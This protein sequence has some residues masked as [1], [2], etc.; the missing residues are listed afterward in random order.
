VDPDRGETGQIGAEMLLGRLPLH[1]RS[2]LREEPDRFVAVTVEEESADR[3][4][5][6]LVTWPKRSFEDWWKEVKG[7]LNPQAG[8]PVSYPYVLPAAPS[9]ACVN[10]TWAN[11][12]TAVPYT[13]T[14]NSMIWTGTEAIVWGGVSPV[15]FLNTGHRYSPATDTWTS[16]A[17]DGSTPSPRNAHTAVWTGSEMIVW[18]GFGP[19]STYL[20][21]GGRYNPAT[22]TWAPV[23]TDA[24]SPT[25]RRGHS[26]IWTGTR[27]IIWGGSSPPFFPPTNY[28]TFLN[29]GASYDPGTDAWTATR[30]DATT[31]EVREGHV[32]VW[33]GTEM[34]LW[35]GHREA[36]TT[37]WTF[38]DLS[39]GGRYNPGTD[40]WTAMGGAPPQ[41]R[42]NHTGI[43]TGTEMIV[44][45]GIFRMINGITGQVTNVYLNSGGRYN[46]STNAWTA[47]RLDG[48]TP[49]ARHVH[50]AV[51]TG[52]QMIVWGG[53]Y[54]TSGST[55]YAPLGGRYN[56]ANDTWAGVY[57]PGPQPRSQHGAVWTGSEM[58]VW[59]GTGYGGTKT[60]GGRYNPATDSWIG[61]AVEPDYYGAAVWTGSEMIV[62]GLSSA[63]DPGGTSPAG[64]YSPATD[65]WHTGSVANAPQGRSSSVA[66]WTG[67]EMIVWGGDNLVTGGRYNPT[68][69][70]WTP[71]MVNGST[72]IARQGG[73]PVAVWTGS[74]MMI[75]GGYCTVTGPCAG[76]RYNPLTDSWTAMRADASAPEKRVLHTGIWT[77]SEMI[78]YGGY[79]GYRPS[80]PFVIGDYARYD[81]A[82]DQWTVSAAPDARYQHTAVWTG[83]EM[84]VWGGRVFDGT[85]EVPT[86]TGQRY[87]PA[88]NAFQPSASGSGTPPARNSH[89]A[90]WDGGEM[91]IWG[92]I[93]GDGTFL[94]DGGRYNP[95][96][97][98]WSPTKLDGTTPLPRY[99]HLAVWTGDEMIIWS[100]LA[101][102]Q[103]SV[104]SFNNGGRYCSCAV[105]V[106][107][108]LDL[109]GDG[110]G[111]SSTGQ[112]F[113][114]VPADRVSAGGD[115][116]DNDPGAWSLPGEAR[117]LTL[118]DN[119]TLVW[120]APITPGANS[121]LYDLIRSPT[122]SDFTGSGTCVASNTPSLGASDAIMP[123][124]GSA[125][126]YLVR[127]ENA[128]P[129]GMGPLGNNSQGNPRSALNCP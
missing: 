26:A 15:G 74:E 14:G 114:G 57:S 23:K 68:L 72:P 90:V 117:D 75:W 5:L 28:P 65:T 32:A 27:M 102:F 50:T 71:T 104:V 84:I 18:G 49:A 111:D 31:P 7:S 78:I 73:L 124:P 120:S 76:G 33:T 12:H 51:W 62:W 77:G 121:L 110:T 100:G 109:D 40:T 125:L 126:Y 88:A 38:R 19:G 86:N 97:G 17:V 113:C 82:A 123:P 25:A 91:I 83:T 103:G 43:W 99:S 6:A 16:T 80:A 122:A 92:G 79:D 37:P 98:S 101:V 46:P 44:W 10:D 13:R 47:T 69:D 63:V 107:Y 35:G 129:G 59:G 1:R 20:G 9:Q 81:P 128:C 66:V 119:V 116:N 54:V 53:Q 106:T 85:N 94:N 58:I 112:A 8:I 34:I 11:V 87:D 115:C 60:T 3:I 89:S 4:K 108:Y 48:T 41:A 29:T 61:T 56:P 22:D 93:A 24:T 127:A 95:G 36:P 64:L 118:T 45:G 42:S 105:P 21:T 55:I 39:T 52:S 2:G 67:S 96:T 30:T 70:V